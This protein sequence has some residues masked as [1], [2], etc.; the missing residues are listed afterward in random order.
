MDYQEFYCG[1]IINGFCHIEIPSKDLNKA[2]AFY[3][4]VFNWKVNAWEGM[5]RY[6]VFETGDGVGGG[7]T[8][9]LEISSKGGPLL[10]IQVEDIPDSLKKVDG[11]GG[12]TVTPK[13]AIP[14]MGF[15]AVFSDAEGNQ[16]GLYSD[17]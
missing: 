10:Y 11:H 17:K 12:K 8:P 3:E 16:I 14:G 6:M 13:T 2:K 4:G 15:Y 9:S 7:T 1:G 5:D